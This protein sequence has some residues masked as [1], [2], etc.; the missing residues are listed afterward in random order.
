MRQALLAPILMVV[1]AIV[2]VVCDPWEYNG[3]DTGDQISIKWETPAVWSAATVKEWLEKDGEHMV[4]YDSDFKHSSVLKAGNWRYE[5]KKDEPHLPVQNISGSSLGSKLVGQ[6]IRVYW[7][8]YIKWHDGV[9]KQCDITRGVEASLYLNTPNSPVPLPQV[10]SETARSNSTRWVST[11]TT[12]PTRSSAGRPSSKQIQTGGRFHAQ[13]STT[14][15]STSWRLTSITTL[16]RKCA[17]GTRPT[18]DHT[19]RRELTAGTAPM[20]T[21]KAFH[22]PSLSL[23]GTRKEP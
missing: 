8:P 5:E 9:V 17:V 18:W 6:R 20:L 16:S 19:S 12:S 7:E 21:R 23:C 15:L 2:T 4:L 14:R 1:N 10:A 3:P 11:T 22:F 13:R